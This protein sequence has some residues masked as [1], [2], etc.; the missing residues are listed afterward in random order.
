VQ[1]SKT[2]QTY[3]FIVSRAVTD[4]AVA[5]VVSKE[6]TRKVAKVVTEVAVRMVAEQVADISVEIVTEKYW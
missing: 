1:V 4:T 2:C 3:S 5:E 6:V